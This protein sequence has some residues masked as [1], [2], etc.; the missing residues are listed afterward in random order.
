MIKQKQLLQ[1]RWFNSL[2]Y[3]MNAILFKNIGY[4]SNKMVNILGRFTFNNKPIKI[5]MIEYDKN[6]KKENTDE[7]NDDNDNENELIIVDDEE[8]ET[9]KKI[10]LDKNQKVKINVRTYLKS[11]YNY[12]NLSDT[13]EN[14]VI[15]NNQNQPNE[16]G[17]ECDDVNFR[18]QT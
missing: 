8:D 4:S 2:S 3:K 6:I 1:I 14:Y 13:N 18:I 7:E 9:H 11:G 5:V 15:S 16:R 10:S 17:I 12:T